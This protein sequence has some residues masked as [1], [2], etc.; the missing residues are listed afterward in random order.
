MLRLPS[1]GG[2]YAVPSPVG[3]EPYTLPYREYYPTEYANARII[4]PFDGPTPDQQQSQGGGQQGQLIPVSGTSTFID[5]YG[6]AT[7][8]A[9]PFKNPVTIDVSQMSSPDSGIGAESI[10]PRD[11]S[12]QPV[13]VRLLVTRF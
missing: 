3:N 13:S 8:L 2:T 9:Q 6:R 1:A 11:T 4:S 5:R 12:I 7:V 10:T